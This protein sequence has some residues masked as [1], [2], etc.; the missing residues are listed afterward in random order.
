SSTSQVDDIS[1]K[2]QNYIANEKINDDSES[3]EEFIKEME[4]ILGCSLEVTPE[5]KEK[6]KIVSELEGKYTDTFGDIISYDEEYIGMSPDEKI[7]TIQE[8]LNTNKPKN[9]VWGGYVPSDENETGILKNFKAF[10]F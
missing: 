1:D 4:A 3:F 8:C 5:Y 7:Q 2:K 9:I 10:Y 6:L